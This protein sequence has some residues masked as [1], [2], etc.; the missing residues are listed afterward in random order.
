MVATA[1]FWRTFHHDGKL[2][3]TAKGGGARRPPFTVFTNMYEVVVHSPAERTD[4]LSVFLLYSYVLCGAKPRAY[5]CKSFLH[6]TV[7]DLT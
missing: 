5:L 4:T 3:Q 7:D 2:A 6:S 1:A